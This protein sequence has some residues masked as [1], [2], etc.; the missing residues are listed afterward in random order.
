[1]GVFD[2]NGYNTSTA[3][4]PG[5]GW[6]AAEAPRNGVHRSSLLASVRLA[7]WH[8]VQRLADRTPPSVCLARV[9]HGRGI[10]PWCR[11][12]RSIVIGPIS[13]GPIIFRAILVW[14]IIIVWPNNDVTVRPV[15]VRPIVWAIVRPNNVWS[16]VVRWVPIVVRHVPLDGCWQYRNHLLCTSWIVSVPRD[17][18]RHTTR[19]IKV[20]PDSHAILRVNCQGGNCRVVGPSL[21]S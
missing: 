20:A 21:C 3:P 12:G 19:P 17:I 4:G 15:I 9:T 11:I 2:P 10:S 8:L 13:V 18:L 16:V 1:L 14:S 6:L 5:N 7:P